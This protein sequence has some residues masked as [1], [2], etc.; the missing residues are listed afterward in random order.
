VEPR[1]RFSLQQF[2]ALL[3]LRN[4]EGKPY[5]II[6]GQAVGFWAET[7]LKEEP[8]LARWLPFTSKDIDF[9]GG[10]SDVLRIAKDLGVRAQLPHSREMSALAGIV[11]LKIGGMRTT[12]ELLRSFPGMPTTKIQ[13]WALSA[14]SVGKEV[15]VGRILILPP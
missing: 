6:G 12:V 7:Y 14:T 13:Q 4:A 3:N 9:H 11:P 1:A 10:R 5:V 15:R 8:E 2:T